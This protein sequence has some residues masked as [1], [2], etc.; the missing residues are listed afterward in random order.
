MTQQE[1]FQNMTYGQW[2]EVEADSTY[3]IIK[4]DEQFG[5]IFICEGIRGKGYG[6]ADALAITSAVN[7]T[8]G[9]GI[10]PESVETLVKLLEEAGQFI[11]DVIIA[12]YA[13]MKKSPDLI[14]ER[15]KEA[16]TAATLH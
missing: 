8:Y 9:K 13:G 16:L 6:M 7:N 3:S 15:I 5:R 10:N 14:T 11:Q 2:K 12:K 1:I 4:K